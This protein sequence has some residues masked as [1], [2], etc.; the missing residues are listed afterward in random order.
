MYTVSRVTT[1]IAREES[2]RR[3]RQIEGIHPRVSF[4]S[5]LR[6]CVGMCC[7]LIRFEKGRKSSR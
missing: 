4:L 1:Y 2:N 7:S 5:Y 3:E 6:H